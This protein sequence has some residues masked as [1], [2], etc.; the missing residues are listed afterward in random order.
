MGGGMCLVSRRYNK[1][2]L[3]AFFAFLLFWMVPAAAGQGWNGYIFY[4]IQGDAARFLS[5]S[6]WGPS[7]ADIGH[8]QQ[9]GFDRVLEEQFSAPASGYP[10]LPLV[11]TTIPTDCDATCRRDNYTLYP[12]QTRFYKNALYEPDQ[13]RQ[14]VA[15][16]LHQIIV[17][18]GVEIT[19]PSRLTPYLQILD[20]NAFGNFR[21]LLQEI[22]LNPAMG[23]YLDMA[24]NNAAN[25]NENYAREVL[26]LFSIGLYQ[27]N[28]DGTPVVGSDGL[29][30][31]AYDQSVV[32]A[33]A[34]VFTGWN[35]APAPAP[36]IV[37][38]ADPMVATQGRHDVRAKTLLQGVTLPANQTAAKDLS[39]ALDNI[40]NHPNVGPFIS[41]QLIQH[42]V[43]T[44]PSPAYVQRVAQVFADN[45]AGVRGDLKAVVRAILMDDDAA[46]N[47]APEEGKG[48]L[49]H[50]V[51]LVTSL[52]RALNARSAEGLSLSDG[53]LNPQNQSMGMDLFLPPSVF[54]Y[55][56]P[57]T[58]NT[59]TVI[60]R[61]NFVNTMVFARIAVSTVAPNGTSL[62]FSAL[63]NISSQ[64]EWMVYVLNTLM[65]NG[66]MSQPMTDAIVAAVN[67][68]PATNTL[69]RAQTAVYLVATS[70]QYQVSR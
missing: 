14:R 13:L 44:N 59:S 34:R 46:A 31:P 49:R 68:V 8:V 17:V 51:L 20:R 24:G 35:F 38:Y 56:Y 7:L 50:P 36:G 4:P 64:P 10:T 60:R 1:F 19:Q 2:R 23:N 5:Y 63:Q 70:A 9:V 41:R 16:A 27:L 18:S 21:Q 26:Q 32:N 54:G 30:L 3:T 40:F 28:E 45:G 12:L 42:L 37:N 61:A 58:F 53:Y 25:P 62:D 11:P 55:F 65:M 39:D 43:T 69:R 57:S 22:T 48:Q 52:L 29:P 6:T 47:P 33:F 66:M 15:F 67:A